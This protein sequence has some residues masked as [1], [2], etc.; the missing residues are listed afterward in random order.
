[1][2]Y[3]IIIRCHQIF[4]CKFLFEESKTHVFCNDLSLRFLKDYDLMPSP[5]NIRDIYDQL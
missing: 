1:M 4:S 3:K 2:R 5:H